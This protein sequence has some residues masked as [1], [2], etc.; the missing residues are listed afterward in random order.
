MNK[1]AFIEWIKSPLIS[2]VD[3][4]FEYN[5]HNNE[6][7]YRIYSKDG[8]LYKITFC[9]GNADPVFGKKGWDYANYEP[10]EVIK[11]AKWV[12]TNTYV[13]VKKE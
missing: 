10:Q 6:K 5:E 12:L 7:G 4:H 11:V 2:C 3:S 9:N 8:K 13:P 1:E